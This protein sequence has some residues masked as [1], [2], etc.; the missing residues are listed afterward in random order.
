M[1]HTL[2]GYYKKSE[3]NH[4]ALIKKLSCGTCNFETD[5]Q[6]SSIQHI[7]KTHSGRIFCRNDISPDQ[8]INEL[9]IHH[10]RLGNKPQLK[11]PTNETK[12]PLLY[13]GDSIS[14][15]INLGKILMV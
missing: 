4:E 2:Y 14:H 6:N 11:Y 3:I 1:T 10:N 7:E 13:I 5:D 12:K 9:A 8:T 15:N